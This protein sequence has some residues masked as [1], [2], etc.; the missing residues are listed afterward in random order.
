MKNAVLTIG[1]ALAFLISG[2]TS[3]PGISEVP[4]FTKV[5][6]SSITPTI[7]VTP[8]LMPE[9]LESA[10][11]VPSSD[12]YAIE[13]THN[14]SSGLATIQAAAHTCSGLRGPWEGN[15]EVV[16]NAGEM[17]VQGAG[18]FNFAFPSDEWAV[19]GEAPFSGGGMV[20]GANCAILDVSDP[21]QF[22]ITIEPSEPSADIIMGSVGGG[23]ITVQCGDDPPRTI[24][25]AVAWGPNPLTIPI[26]RYSNCP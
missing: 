4:T 12:G 17:S 26:L 15:F 14:V 13:F 20:S 6:D 5:P 11:A 10:T 16:M 25:F 3:K 9:I 21:L 24:P 1:A 22:E 7:S 2:C 23:T 18:P 8:S 19:Q